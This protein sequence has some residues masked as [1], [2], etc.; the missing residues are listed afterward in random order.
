MVR[1]LGVIVA[2]S[3]AGLCLVVL[4]FG[5]LLLRGGPGR[6]DAELRASARGHA[7]PIDYERPIEVRVYAPRRYDGGVVVVYSALCPPL[8]GAEGP[9]REIGYELE[10]LGPARLRVAGGGF[11]GSAP[12]RRAGGVEYAGV[13]AL[14][15]LPA[16]VYGRVLSAEV[17]AVE[18]LFSDGEVLRDGA[19][20]RGFALVSPGARGPCELRLLGVGGCVLLRVGIAVQPG[21]DPG[22]VRALDRECRALSAAR[23]AGTPEWLRPWRIAVPATAPGGER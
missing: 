21:I 9:Q 6:S 15:G 17:E 12:P 5:C 10:F 7:C 4:L 16:M 23:P 19:E 11:V 22:E 14:A 13:R 8:P 18:V 20:D 1:G 3:S 2:V